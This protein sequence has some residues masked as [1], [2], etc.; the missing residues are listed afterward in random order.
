MINK[1]DIAEVCYANASVGY[2]AAVTKNVFELEI[3]VDKAI[4]M[5]IM[6]G[7]YDLAHDWDGKFLGD[8]GTVGLDVLFQS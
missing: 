7:F 2:A 1:V 4:G 3:S 5:E 6:T 8:F